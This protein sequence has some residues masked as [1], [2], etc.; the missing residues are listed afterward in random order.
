LPI[1]GGVQSDP[2]KPRRRTRFALKLPHRTPRLEQYLLRKILTFVVGQRVRTRH[3]DDGRAMLFQPF[4][5]YRFVI[6]VKHKRPSQGDAKCRSSSIGTNY[7]LF[8]TEKI[9]RLKPFDVRRILKCSTLLSPTS[10]TL[11][12]ARFVFTLSETGVRS[13]ST[14]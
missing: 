4:C 5:E 11:P 10:S 9:K 6:F 14:T 12:E 8:L 2:I 1:H 13:G 7:R 3:L